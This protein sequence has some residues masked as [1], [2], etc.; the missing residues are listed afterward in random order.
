MYNPNSKID[1]KNWF[2]YKKFD[3]KG[4][5]T[6]PDGVK[7]TLAETHNVNYNNFGLIIN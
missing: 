6:D 4:A 5:Y 7:Y 1:K 2:S 3:S